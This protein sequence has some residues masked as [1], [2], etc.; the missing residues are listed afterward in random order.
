M[1]HGKLKGYI[2]RI[3]IPVVGELQAGEVIKTQ[4]L[5]NPHPFVYPPIPTNSTK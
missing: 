1:Q 5:A 4:I 3:Q 2:I